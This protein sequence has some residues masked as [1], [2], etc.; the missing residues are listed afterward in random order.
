MPKKRKL[1][2]NIQPK[3]VASGV[4]ERLPKRKKDPKARLDEAIQTLPRITNDTIAAHR[5]EVI[6]SARKYIYPLRHTNHRTVLISSTLFVTFIVAF[7]AYAILALYKF[8]VNSA[9][10]YRVTEVIPFPV[11]KVGPSWVSYE[12]YLFQ[13]RHY[14]HYY[15]TQQKIDFNTQAG[16][17][18]LANYKKQAMTQVID[19]ALVK[20]L[21]AK[22]H[23]TVTS[24]EVNNEIALVR[25]QDQLG[26]NPQVF[27]EVLNEFW[28]WSIND[29]K[30]ELKQQLL[31]QKVVSALDTATHQRAEAALLQ[32]QHGANFAT[33]AAQYSQDTATKNNGGQFASP[34]TNTDE[35]IPPQTLHTLFSLQPGQISGI[36]NIGYGLEIDKVISR[37]GNSVVAAHILFNFKSLN[38]YLDPTLKKE[39]PS[40]FINQPM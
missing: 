23:V 17:Q 29:F 31:A 30:N 3:K 28:G 8:Q 14:E 40:I 16:Q 2:I 34:I 7:F 12:N 21:A 25:N 22:H 27:A 15:E 39:K 33:V 24:Q 38:S 18:Q 9:F 32:L 10:L 35:S 6:G 5:E 26:S 37:Q 20:Q 1:P 19:N 11:A 4:I 13:L 36:V